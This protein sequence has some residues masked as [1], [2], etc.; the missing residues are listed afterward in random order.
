MNKSVLVTGINGFIG[1]HCVPFLKDKFNEIHGISRKIQS[2]SDGVAYHQVDFTDINA[3]KELVFEI[4]PTH[5]LHLAWVT[6]HGKYWYSH[7]NMLW[8]RASLEF[9]KNLSQNDVCKVVTAGTCA[10]YD[11]IKAGNFSEESTIYPST[12]YGICKASL[13]QLSQNYFSEQNISYAWGRIFFTYGP[14]ESSS[15]LVPTIIQSL[16]R[17]E[18]VPLTS[19]EQLRD[20]LYVEDV[21][22]CLCNLLVST[23]S[24]TFNISSGEEIKL[25]DIAGTI[26]S[27]TDRSELLKFNAIPNRANEPKKI[28]GINAKIQNSLDFFPKVG[29]KEGLQRTL[30]WWKNHV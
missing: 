10:E 29:L 12:P 15:R 27:L 11:W 26:G 17:G 21:A 1:R 22:R 2:K 23:C 18:E 30:E 9:F 7:E 4:K 25:K 14:H 20:F 28:V 16:L 19:G 13:N 6:E 8:L 24:G 5:V 3:I